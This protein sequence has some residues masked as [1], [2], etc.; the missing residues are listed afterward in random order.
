[1]AQPNFAGFEGR[2]MGHEPKNMDFLQKLG[3]KEKDSFLEPLDKN[4]S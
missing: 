4:T 2:G 1:M 3:E